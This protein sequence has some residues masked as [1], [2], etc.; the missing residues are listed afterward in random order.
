MDILLNHDLSFIGSKHSIEIMALN[1]TTKIPK[2]A[3]R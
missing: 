3:I 2:K 1:Q